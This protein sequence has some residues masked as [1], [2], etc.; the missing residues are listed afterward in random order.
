MKLRAANSKRLIALVVLILAVP[1]TILLVRT[2]QEVRQRAAGGANASL[3]MPTTISQSVAL[4]FNVP[5]TL[6]TDG[7]GIRGVDVV[8]NFDKTKLQVVSVTPNAQAAT[9]LKSFAPVTSTGSFDT[10]RVIAD[11]NANGKIE[12][13]AVTYDWTAQAPTAAYNGAT[14]LATISFRGTI[15]GMTPITFQFTPGSTTDTNIVSDV[16]PPVDLLT[17]SGQLVNTTVTLVGDPTNTPTPT[18]SVTATPTPT[19][20]PTLT[21]TRTPTLTGVPPTN[22]PTLTPVPGSTMFNFIM[23]LHGIGNGGD[24][25]NPGSVG[26]TNPLT[27]QRQ[28]T[29]QVLDGTNAVVLTKNGTVSYNTGTGFFHGAVDMGS[30]LASGPYLVRIKSPKYLQRGVPGIKVIT[31]GQAYDMGTIDLIVGDVN[32]D[33]T[34]NILDY[35]MISDCY[36]DLAPA[37]NCSDPAKKFATDITDDGDVNQFDYN[38]F[39]RELSV[40]PGE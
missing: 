11:A 19:R 17:Q 12:F 8:L 34:L 32:N 5:I 20:T 2:V 6:S 4:N 26:N 35:N 39:I 23:K 33:N 24:S 14:T 15:A 37:R 9:S 13:G 3:T 22:T 10:A 28:V 27:T 40:R 1:L 29:V 31:S 38:I 7:V 36:S 16:N 18:I 21:P 25:V 30:T